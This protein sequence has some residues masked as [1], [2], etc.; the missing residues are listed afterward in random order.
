MHLVQVHAPGDVR[1]DKVE[2]P[3]VGPRDALVRIEACGICGTDL[4]FIRQGGARQGGTSP[5]P[6]GHEAAGRII[7]VG[8]EVT[9]VTVG[10]HVIINPMGSSAVIGNGGPEGAFTEELLVR[11]AAL[12]RSLLEVPTGLSSEFAA[13]AEPLGV[14]MH[15]VNRSGA[16]PGEKVVVFGCGP[17]GLGAVLWLNHFGV[18]DVIAVDM[19]DERLELA[20][21]MGARATINAGRENLSERLKE[22]HGTEM[23][24]GREAA[25]THAYIDAAGAPTVV[26]DVVGMARTH[27]RLVVI[28]AYRAPVSL[29]LSAMLLS[30]MSITTSIGYPDELQRVLETLPDLT[31][32]L[33]LLI[34]HRFPFEK[35]I[36][37]FDTAGK[38]DAAK[39]M[40]QFGVG[41]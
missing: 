3:L 4:T 24:M 27:A 37:A 8:P 29:D 7:A 40:I 31:E 41:E 6:L 5:L 22:L 34:S 16:K 38:G 33:E 26:P 35:V 17:I 21:A 39:V 18:E 36:E 23:V 19:F 13:L 9:D 20:M 12:G 10:Q 11:D 32:K 30:E 25:G 1:L 2:A 15:G 14:A 28:A